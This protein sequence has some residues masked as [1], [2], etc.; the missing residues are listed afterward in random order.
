MDEKLYQ[1]EFEKANRQEIEEQEARME[2]MILESE[3]QEARM[4]EKIRE[5]EAREARMEQKVREIEAQEARM[6]HC[7]RAEEITIGDILGRIDT[8]LIERDYIQQVIDSINHIPV[9]DSPNGGFDGQARGQALEAI[10]TCRETTNQRV[11]SLMEKMYDDIVH[12]KYVKDAK[13]DAISALY[14]HMASLAETQSTEELLKSVGK[15]RDVIE[16][17]L[18]ISPWSD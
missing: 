3:A 11:L 12:P 10:V 9:N 18:Q 4:E 8:I 6:Q 5:S 13:S 17:V 16:S 1:Q 2:R 14:R 15:M 7:P